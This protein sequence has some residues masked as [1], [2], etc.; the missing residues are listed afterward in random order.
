MDFNAITE[1]IT[2]NIFSDQNDDWLVTLH[3]F[4]IFDDSTKLVQKHT[5]TLDEMC[6]MYEKLVGDCRE[7]YGLPTDY[8][9]YLSDDN[10]LPRS[11]NTLRRELVNVT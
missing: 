2:I 1:K 10:E 3:S 4:S 5:G 6:V 9:L 11:L 8:W 7:K